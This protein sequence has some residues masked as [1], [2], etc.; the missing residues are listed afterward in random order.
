[1]LA[2]HNPPS[3][4]SRMTRSSQENTLFSTHENSAIPPLPPPF[5]SMHSTTCTDAR[6]SHA[7]LLDWR[8]P[9]CRRHHTASRV[10][11]GTTLGAIDT[12]HVRIRTCAS[13]YNI[14]VV[15][16]YKVALVALY[17]SRL[18]DPAVSAGGSPSKSKSLNMVAAMSVC[19]QGVTGSVKSYPR[20][21][22]RPVPIGISNTTEVSSAS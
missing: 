4:D 17:M 8:E 5:F 16:L 10:P 12:L 7:I 22:M 2:T 1:M 6:L 21:R 15:A 9:G 19:T 14:A 13:L 18:T 20:Y 3:I 11:R